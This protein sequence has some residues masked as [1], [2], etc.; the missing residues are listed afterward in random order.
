MATTP[1]APKLDHLEGLN[2][3][4]ETARQ[5]VID[6]CE[7]LV[8]P[9]LLSTWQVSPT[10]QAWQQAAAA[11][12]E[13]VT[14]AAAEVRAFMDE[15]ADTWLESARGEAYEAF[16]DALDAAAVE[17]EPQDTLRLTI[18]IDLE[19]GA[20]EGTVENA[21]DILPETPELPELDA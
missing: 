19:S 18:T 12:N 21:D 20:M 14:D 9:A 15:H 10:F 13:A 1:K 5:E 2:A 6:L 16:A 11:W 17:P 4:L 3:A 7:Q 8:D